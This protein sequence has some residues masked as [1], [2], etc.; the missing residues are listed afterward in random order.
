MSKKIKNITVLMPAYNSSLYID[1][2]VKS[3]LNQTFKEFEFLIIDDGS[4]DNSEE[5]ISKYKDSRINYTKL[6]HRGISVA[7]NYGIKKAS[8]DW[9]ARIDA[10]DLNTPD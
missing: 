5:E 9:I 2:A 3:I 10:D 8:C 1:S 6:K 4:A 7:L